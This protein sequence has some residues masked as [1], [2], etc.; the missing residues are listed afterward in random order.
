MKGEIYNRCDDKDFD[1][2]IKVE[3]LNDLKSGASKVVL[4]TNTLHIPHVKTCSASVT[5][6][7]ISFG[8][9]TRGKTNTKNLNYDIKGGGRISFT[10]SS[11]DNGHLYLGNSSDMNISV[12]KKFIGPMYIWETPFHSNSGII[13]MELNVSTKA[14][15]GESSATLTATLNCP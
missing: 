4:L 6:D 7:K 12:P 13:P 2:T 9:V 15:S 10:S 3:S 5:P 11:M 8:D 14:D 1:I